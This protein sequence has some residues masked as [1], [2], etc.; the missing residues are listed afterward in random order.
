MT[1]LQ[2]P[3]RIVE[4]EILRAVSIVFLMFVHSD[5][6]SLII[7]GV[8]LEPVGPYMGTFMLGSFFFMAGYFAEHSYRHREKRFS[9]YMASKF[10]RL[11][12]PYWL[13]LALFILV[14]GYTLKRFDFLVYLFDL[15]F[16]FSPTYV[17]LLLTLWYLSVVFAYYVIFGLMLSRSNLQLLLWALFI[18][19]IAYLLNGLYDLFDERFFEYYF[20]F[21]S[22][23]YLSRLGWLRERVFS[24]A[25]PAKLILALVGAVLFGV[26]EFGDYRTASWPYVLGTV[27]YILSWIALALTAFRSGLWNWRIWGPLSYAAFFAYLYHRPIWTI[28]VNSLE[29]PPGRPQVFFQLIPG[30]IIVLV[31]C[32]YL[33][34]GYDW[35]L[36]TAGNL[37]KGSTDQSGL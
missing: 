22:G 19:G 36:Q 9:T 4:F 30:S 1:A 13:A 27:F 7:F 5:V 10:V 6:F 26:V 33:Q 25:V 2:K 21:L 8:K 20:V 37:W 28:L 18:Y 17:K 31:T 3:G 35:L 14:M 23:I 29:I 24:G 34:R 32:F 15:Q 12:P 16:I 11:F